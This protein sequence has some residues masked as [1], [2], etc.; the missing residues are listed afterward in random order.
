MKPRPQIREY[1]IPSNPSRLN[2]H[3]EER[4]DDRWWQAA[5]NVVLVLCAAVA[6]F[7]LYLSVMG[8]GR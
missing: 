8:F 7:D 4:D 2:P 5:T 6:A 3:I 1:R